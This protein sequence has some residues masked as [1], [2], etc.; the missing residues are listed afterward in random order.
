MPVRP[1]DEEF[2]TFFVQHF[3]R[4]VTSLTVITGDRDRATDA[5]QEAFIK[6]YAKWSKIRSYDLPAAWVRRIAINATRDTHRAERRRA[7]REEAQVVTDVVSD[8]HEIVGLDFAARLLAGLPRRQREVAALFYV[9]D[10]SV[11][12]VALTLGLSEGTVKSHLSEARDR[13][14]RI[15]EAEKVQ[16]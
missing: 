11:Q 2:E 9:D 6:A 5:T 3:D 14:R 13:M 16:P 10:Y 15:L 7:N 8:V 4:I 12:E 1:S